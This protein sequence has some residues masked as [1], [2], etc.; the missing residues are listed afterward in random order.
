MEDTLQTAKE[1]LSEGIHLVEA[2]KMQAAKSKLTK[3][4][5]LDAT[6]IDGWWW[7]AQCLDASD[8]R[9]Y[10]LQQVLK[11]DP[12]HE[13]ARSLLSEIE[14]GEQPQVS[15]T[16]GAVSPGESSTADEP[17]GFQLQTNEKDSPVSPRRSR[18]YLIVLGSMFA[19]A[20]FALLIVWLNSQDAIDNLL[21]STF[22]RNQDPQG[23]A[24]PMD[25][26]TL[27]QKWT[28]TPLPVPSPTPSVGIATVTAQASRIEEAFEA[29]QQALILMTNENYGQ[30]LILLDR[31]IDLDPNFADAYYYRGRAYM[32]QTSY[33]RSQYEYLEY[34]HKA[35]A[36][37]D[38]AIELEPTLTGDYYLER[39][40]AYQH[41]A[42][43]Q[44]L[45]VDRE[46]YI[47]IALENLRPG[48]S[49]LN[50]APFRERTEVYYLIYLGQC[51]EALEMLQEI[52]EARGISAAPSGFINQQ[53]ANIDLCTG[54]Y[55]QALEKYE[56][57][58]EYIGSVW[59]KYDI[60][61]ILYILG[62]EDEAFELINEMLEINPYYHGSRYYLRALIHAD[63]GDFEQ[64]ETD[65]Q[66]GWGYTWDHTGLAEYVLAQLAFHD[67]DDAFVIEALKMAEATMDGV[68]GDYFIEKWRGELAAMGESP[69]ESNSTL[70]LHPTPIPALPSDI[71][72]E[73]RPPRR[74]YI[75]AD[76]S[77]GPLVIAPGEIVD[78]QVVHRSDYLAEFVQELSI[79]LGWESLDQTIDAMIMIPSKEDQMLWANVQAQW[80][81]NPIIYPDFYIHKA[82]DIYIRLWNTSG[83]PLHLADVGVRVTVLTPGGELI[84]YSMKPYG[85]Q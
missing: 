23:V 37:L 67:G 64:A 46:Q 55:A 19:I 48:I 41:L 60:A 44:D 65:L 2:G 70:D 24:L 20:F 82:G 78:I 1:L 68:K 51:D 58:D 33:L 22:G 21:N 45:R 59:T 84:T 76:E 9:T 53:L 80:G 34:V 3:A 72:V 28:A 14:G 27:P 57:A 42:G 79:F 83:M 36:D 38:R 62:Q 6:L 50:T 66:T 10:C 18:T 39:A 73:F 63:R 11:L 31:T 40:D 8:Q 56:I 4:V 17:S 30:A 7:L 74:I 52:I 29:F 16:D 26:R 47:A 13:D 15:L 25:T 71:P 35:I 81:N 77:T 43:V 5:Q 85:S 61:L 49:L 75:W 12:R 69:L 32:E 54:N